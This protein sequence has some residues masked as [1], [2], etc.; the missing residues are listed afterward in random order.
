MV[1]NPR[2]LEGLA[3]P[4]GFVLVALGRSA[5]F[6]ENFQIPVIAVVDRERSLRSLV[7]V[8]ALSWL[9]NLLSHSIVGAS[10]LFVGLAAA[11][12]TWLDVFIWFPVATIGNLTGGVGL[13]TLLR[14]G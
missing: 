5:L 9:G 13:V 1:Q 10:I 7:E 3:F 11:Y 2:R 12:R 8:S 14:V 4:I 6:A